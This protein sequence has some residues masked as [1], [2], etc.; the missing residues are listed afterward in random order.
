MQRTDINWGCKRMIHAHEYPILEYSTEREAVIEPSKLTAP[1]DIAPDCV[2]TFFKE[3]LDRMHEAGALRQVA[4]FC[5]ENGSVPI[6]ELT[7]MDQRIAVMNPPVGAPGSVAVLEELIALGCCRFMVCGGAGVLQKDIAV[8]HLI[9][10]VS[11]VRD[12]GTS[13]HYMPPSREV[14]P[15]A[16][17]RELSS[18]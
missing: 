7:Y 3:V 4:A 12:E 5:S 2:L 6:Y 10:P 9:L 1:I 18:L 11:A 16:G 13:Y 17:K 8:G 14:D 15:S